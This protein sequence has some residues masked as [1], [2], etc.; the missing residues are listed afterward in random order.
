MFR[1]GTSIFIVPR[2]ARPLLAYANRTPLYSRRRYA[3][4]AILTRIST[5]N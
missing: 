4:F 5:T 1:I 3:T 2:Y